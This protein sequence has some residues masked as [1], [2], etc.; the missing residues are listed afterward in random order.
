MEFND[1]RGGAQLKKAQLMQIARQFD[2]TETAGSRRAVIK[3][4]AVTGLVEK[5]IPTGASEPEAESSAGEEGDT[6]E[7][8]T[9]PNSEIELNLDVNLKVE[10]LKD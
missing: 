4:A 2:I 8:S 10:Q 5:Q 7:N 3:Q 6:E 1:N 9:G